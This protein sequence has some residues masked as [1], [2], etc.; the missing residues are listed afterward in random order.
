MTRKNQK[1]N[2]MLI[3]LIHNLKKQASVNET[4]IWKDIAIRLEKSLK[5]WPAVNLNKIDKYVSEKEIA[6]IPGKVLSEGNLN[7]KITIAAWS[8]SEKSQEKI[9]KAGGKSISIQELMKDNPKGENIRIL[10]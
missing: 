9:K 7:K 4:P 10:G 8:F 3:S 2:P 1:T 6:L 5:N